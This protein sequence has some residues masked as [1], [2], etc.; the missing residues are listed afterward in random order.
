MTPPAR[1]GRGEVR[2]LLESAGL[3]PRRSLGQNFVVDPNTVERIARLARVGPGDRVVEIGPG[4][5]SLTLAL[6]ATGAAVTAVEIDH[7][8]TTVLRQLVPAS[9]TVVEADARHCDW[10]ALL[11]EEPWVLVANLPYNVATPLVVT[12]LES[13]P[14]IR[15]ML[16]M[17]QREAGERLGAAPGGREYG[18]VTVRVAYF[19]RARLV[20]QVSPE[21]FYPRPNVDSV[22]VEIERRDEPAVDPAVASYAEMDRLVRAGFAGRRKMLRRALAG[23]VDPEVFAAAGVDPS[24]RAEQLDVVTWG[25]LAGCQRSIASGRPP[26]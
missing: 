2:R 19:A 9:V 11:G 16:V 23:L 1:L 21:V 10:P 13:V 7:G 25:K 14:Q 4:L 3:S 20:G 18:A 8:L 12:L 15:R 22:L 6:A 5:G 24:L 17:V 26:S